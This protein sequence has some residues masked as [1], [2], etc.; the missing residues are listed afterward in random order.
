MAKKKIFER[1]YT[2][3]EKEAIIKQVNKDTALLFTILDLAEG[4]STDI[5]GNLN[6]VGLYEKEIKFRLETV[7]K[8]FEN[9]RNTFNGAVN[10][11]YEDMIRFGIASEEV[12]E[13][14]YNLLGLDSHGKTGV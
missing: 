6:K 1:V 8:N 2:R 3:D 4:I 14:I 10:Y 9:F 5:I 11:N 12:K 7:R 13:A